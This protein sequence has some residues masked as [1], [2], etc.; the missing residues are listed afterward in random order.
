MKR[1]RNSFFAF[2]L[3]LGAGSVF[4]P[5]QAATLVFNIDNSKSGI[6]VSGLLAGFAMTQQGSGSLTTSYSGTILAALSGGNIQF[7]GGS[8]LTAHT[9]GVWQPAAGG[10][11]GSAAADYGAQASINYPPF[12]FF[13]IYGAMRNVTFD[14]TSP[15]LPLA[16][17]NFNGT[18][19]VFSFASGNAALDYYFTYKSGSLA[20]TGYATNT[21]ATG[22]TLA[23]N[24]GQ[25]T[26]TIPINTTFHFTLLS[27][28]D[29]TVNLIGQI[30]A[31]NAV[32]SAAPIIQSLTFTNQSVVL[33][34]ANATGQSQ[35]LVSTN[36][37]GWLPASVTTTTN[38]LGWIIFTTPLHGAHAFYRVQQ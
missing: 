14:V 32:A 25:R 11:A 27:A 4:Q 10:A 8:S 1:I 30:V 20:L 38:N 16:G 13:T 5:A 12:G 6:T 28:N 37:A 22:A 2:V 33:A 18:N 15:V 17:T 26:L 34:A 19:L 24:S 36:L 7:T 21:I 3:L 23:T 35:L 31:T 29:T 9:N